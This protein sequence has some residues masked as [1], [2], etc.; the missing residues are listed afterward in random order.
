[1]DGIHD[2]GGM[3]GFG[4]VVVDGDDRPFHEPWEGRVHGMMLALGV[5]G[6]LPAGLRYAKERIEPARYLSITYYEQW[7]DALET[8]L[9]QSGTLAPGELEER[10]AA[11]TPGDTLPERREPGAAEVMR[12]ILQPFS[13]DDPEGPPARFSEGD[14]VVVTR[15]ADPA[16]NRCPRY[17]R[18]ARGWIER[19]RVPQVVPE[20]HGR[21]DG[22]VEHFYT[23]GFDASELWGDG[24]EP[25]TTVLVDLFEEYLEPGGGA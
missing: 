23:V 5:A 16:H 11:L 22:R 9:V 13:V 17:V 8:L 4:P 14:R 6:V 7:L 21:E 12:S 15:H 2:M 20:L 18:G 1:M 25:G 10:V 19:V 3:Q 24:A